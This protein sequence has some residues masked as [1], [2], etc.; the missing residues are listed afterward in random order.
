M[1][2]CQ[3]MLYPQSAPLADPR[4]P[5]LHWVGYAGVGYV[6][7]AILPFYLR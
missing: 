4:T 2:R 1:H 5:T 6:A 3:Q 7:V